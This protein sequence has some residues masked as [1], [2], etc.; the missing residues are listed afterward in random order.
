MADRHR[1]VV[2]VKDGNVSD[3]LFCDCCP[4]VTLE[5]RTYVDEKSATAVA[6]PAWDT[7]GGTSQ[8]SQF[9]RDEDG[10]YEPSYYDSDFDKE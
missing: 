2:L 6:L 9:K 3:V 10:V 1:I 7:D 4:G 8:S 5:V